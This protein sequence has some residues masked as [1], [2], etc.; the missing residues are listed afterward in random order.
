MVVN[1]DTYIAA[2]RDRGLGDP[3]DWPV[4]E[5]CAW[6]YLRMTQYAKEDDKARIDLELATP[7]ELL[8]DGQETVDPEDSG[9]DNFRQQMAGVGLGRA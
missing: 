6:V 2:A 7:P 8:A 4:D 3:T 1:W 9:W 5:L